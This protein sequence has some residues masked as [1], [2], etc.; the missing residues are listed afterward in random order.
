MENLC[1]ALSNAD[2]DVEKYAGKNYG[3]EDGNTNEAQWYY[4]AYNAIRSS[5]EDVNKKGDALA[6]AYVKLQA[7]MDCEK[8]PEDTTFPDKWSGA[9]KDA[10]KYAEEALTNIFS[11]FSE[12]GYKD[13]G[14]KYMTVKNALVSL[15]SNSVRSQYDSSSASQKLKIISEKMTGYRDK[16]KSYIEMLDL[17]INGDGKLIKSEVMSLDDLS[18]LVWEYYGEYD[19]WK[20]KTEK[21][22]TSLGETQQDDLKIYE[23]QKREVDGDDVIEFK[24]KLLKERA[25]LQSIL[26]AIDNVKYGGK[27][28]TDIEDFDGFYSKFKKKF[29]IPSEPLTNSKMKTMAD[30]IYYELMNPKKTEALIPKPDCKYVLSEGDDTYYDFLLSKKYDTSELNSLKKKVKDRDAKLDDYKDDKKDAENSEES[31][32]QKKGKDEIS[33]SSN[34]YVEKISNPE[35]KVTD[36]VGSFAKTIGSFANLNGIDTRDSLY[37]TLYAMNMFSYRTYVYEG[38]YKYNEDNNG[39]EITYSNCNSKY[40][41]LESKWQDENKTFV[42]NKSLTNQMINLENNAANN[43]EIEYILYGKTNEK[44]LEKAYLSIYELRMA[45]NLASGF[46]NFWPEKKDNETAKAIRGAARLIE[47]ATQGIIPAP[48]TKC[49]LIALLAA[50]ESVN[51]MKILNKGIPLEVYKK[52]DKQWAY[53]MGGSGEDVSSNNPKDP[54]KGDGIRMQYSD[55]LFVFLYSTLEKGDKLTNAAY[56]RIGRVIE[57]NMQKVTGDSSYDL[58]NSKTMF[59]ITAE[60]EVP[61]MMMDQPL[62]SDYRKYLDNGQWNR[63]TLKMSRGY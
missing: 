51:D 12:S 2:S 46:V 41:G 50:L 16:I 13:K 35:F 30:N 27:K 21:S 7:M 60:I 59:T 5:I 18:S 20:E 32:K 19:D 10:M 40:A 26:D 53:S 44:N 1:T 33:G 8:D 9:A 14:K 4:F 3:K 34:I 57:A 56:S 37:A 43:A 17:V 42:Y 48:V 54:Q 61:P 29:E 28:I 55:Y 39:A 62:A 45:L 36:I 24:K 15:N 52:T 6:K 63:Y 38:K 23:S 58:K 49:V 22:K 47:K 11:D 25:A 31:K